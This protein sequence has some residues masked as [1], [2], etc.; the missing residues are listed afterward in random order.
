[1]GI[2]TPFDTWFPGPTRVLNPNG[3]SISSA[4]LAGLTS[5]TDRPTDHASRSATIDRIYV[6]GTAMRS[7]NVPLR[8]NVW[9][10]YAPNGQN[11]TSYKV[12]LNIQRQICFKFTLKAK[13]C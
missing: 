9:Q 1:M 10:F 5:V 13:E 8:Y 4:V 11:L 6:R 2:W 7:K 12:C 3:I